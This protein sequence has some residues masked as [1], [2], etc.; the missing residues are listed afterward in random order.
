MYPCMLTRIALSW[1]ARRK[2]FEPVLRCFCQ[3]LFRSVVPQ[4]SWGGEQERETNR[5][6]V[7]ST[8]DSAVSFFAAGT[9]ENA[10]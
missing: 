3:R 2:R 6:K 5:G 1:T 4:G 9:Q 7:L 10:G 8:A